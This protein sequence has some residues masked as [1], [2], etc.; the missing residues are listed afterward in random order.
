MRKQNIFLG[1][2]LILTALLIIL[3]IFGVFPGIGIFDIVVTVFMV[4][5]IILSIRRI[6]FWG[7]F[8]PLAV[9]I[10]VYDRE[11][12]I[13]EFTPWPVLL[14][15]FFLSLGLS[16]IFKR[17]GHYFVHIG[18]DDFVDS[19][20]DEIGGNTINCTTVF[21]DCI[22]YINTENFERATIKTVFGDVKMYFDNAK[23]PSE[24]A[25]IYLDVVF[26]DVDLY[27]PRNWNVQN[28]THAIFGEFDIT[29]NEVIPDSPI[30]NIYG[31][32]I[33]G[34]VKIIFV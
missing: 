3:N 16:L 22:K 30:V 27:I 18:K 15:A 28:K 13:T 17:E 24:K 19:K 32:I 4:V 5:I 1:L 26:G 6:N 8:F 9:I 14:S 10:I 20:V 25:D 29:R 34:D 12:N 21:G 31:N 23:I 2:M 7:I 11:L 33:F